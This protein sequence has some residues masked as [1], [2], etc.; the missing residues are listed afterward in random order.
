MT[1]V[2]SLSTSAPQAEPKLQASS[3]SSPG[4]SAGLRRGGRWWIFA[5][6]AAFGL[7][8]VVAAWMLTGRPSITEVGTPRPL[9]GNGQPQPTQLRYRA[10][11]DD[12]RSI[13]VRFV[14]GD[15]PYQ[16]Q[17]WSVPVKGPGRDAG[18]LD[19]GTLSPQATALQRLT[20]EYT[21]V[22]HEGKRSEPFEKTFDV[23]PPARIIQ[24]VAPPRLTLGQPLTVTVDVQRGS[25]DV[26][27][28]V[29]R[30]IE[31]DVPWPARETMYPVQWTQAQGR[32]Q[33]RLDVPARAQQST[34]ELELVDAAG[35]RSAPVRVAFSAGAA[36]PVVTMA[37]VQSVSYLGGASG[38]GAVGGAVAGG[39][40]GNRFGRGS[41]RAAMTALGAVGGALAG[42]Q[43]EQNLRGASAW[44]TTL[45][46]D[47]GGVRRIRHEQAPRWRAGSRVRV[48]GNQ[49]QG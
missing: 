32:Y 18:T 45:Q 47:G 25:H 1:K 14:R 15:G 29:S 49:I 21:L 9:V 20:F 41:G 44:E 23:V 6:A 19:A 38:L 11:R 2:A 12:I 17:S 4:A 35:H 5:A 37:T 40:L 24:A 26:V 48:V 22:T 13:E 30:V 3:D 7:A 43:V 16:P 28:L 42:H 46:M 10:R 33:L 27:Q 34:L 8:A 36:A 31:S 39:A